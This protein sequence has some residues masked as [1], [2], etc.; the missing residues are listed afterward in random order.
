[1]CWPGPSLVTPIY[2][3]GYDRGYEPI[4]FPGLYDP[5]TAGEVSPL[6]SAFEAA[7]AER[8]ARRRGGRLPADW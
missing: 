4:P 8:H 3:S 6:L 2:I 7:K 1:M 5:L